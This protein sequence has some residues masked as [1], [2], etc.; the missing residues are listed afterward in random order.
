VLI[1]NTFWRF[2]ALSLSKIYPETPSVATLPI[3]T[4][5]KGKAV[6]LRFKG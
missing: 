6:V 1:S 2:A 3:L 4:L 5:G